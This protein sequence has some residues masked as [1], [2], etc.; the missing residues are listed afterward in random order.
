MEK[1]RTSTHMYIYIYV[2]IYIYMY[3]YYTYIYIYITRQNEKSMVQP[4]CWT[5]QHTQLF[6]QTYVEGYPRPKAI[7]FPT[8]TSRMRQWRDSHFL[9]GGDEYKATSNFQVQN[10]LLQE[11]GCIG[12]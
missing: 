9:A 6:M 3:I 2:C 12:C 11:I 7:D 8:S 4:T 1:N 10:D 5:L